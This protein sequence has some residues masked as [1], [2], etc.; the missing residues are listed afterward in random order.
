MSGDAHVRKR[1]ADKR[2]KKVDDSTE[3]TVPLLIPAPSPTNEE[4]IHVHKDAHLGGNFCSKIVFFGLF[5]T[6]AILVGL[7][8]IEFH[9]SGD[10]E[11]AADSPWSVMLEGWVDEAHDNHEHEEEHSV[12]EKDKPY[13]TEAEEHIRNVMSGLRKKKLEEESIEAFDEEPTREVQGDQEEN[14]ETEE[15]GKEEESAQEVIDDDDNEETVGDPSAKVED[16]GEAVDKSNVNDT[17]DTVE[18]IDRRESLVDLDTELPTPSGSEDE[19]MEDRTPEESEDEQVS[20]NYAAKTAYEASATPADSEAES[21]AELTDDEVDDTP[22]RWKNEEADAQTGTEEEEEEEEEEDEEEEETEEEESPPPSPPKPKIQPEQNPRRRGGPRSADDIDFEQE[23]YEYTDITNDYD[24]AIRNEL[25]FAEDEFLN[26]SIERAKSLFS[27]LLVEHPKSVRAYYGFARCIDQIAE[28]LKSNTHLL[29]A[30]NLYARTL[31]LPDISDALYLRVANRTI[32]RMRF[33]GLYQKLIPIHRSLI[34]RFHNDPIHRNN[35][36]VTFLLMNRLNDAK[37]VLEN[38][39]NRWPSDGMAAAHYG[40]ILKMEDNLEAGVKYLKNG[41]ESNHS[42]A[43]DSRFYFH[44]GDALYR[45]GRN[46]EALKVYEIG[47]KRGMFRSLYQRSLYNIDRLVSR[48]WWTLEQTTYASFFRKL[49]ENWQII[50]NEAQA[51]LTKN[52]EFVDEAE[53]LRSVGDWKQFEL[54][55]R[56]RKI[57]DNCRKAPVTCGI[58]SSFEA[59]STCSRGQVKFS[60]M[61]PG[62]H[63]R[64]HCGPTNCRLRAHLGLIVPADTF[65]RVAEEIRSWKE[66]KVLVFDDSFEHEVWH[67]G[68]SARLVLIVDTWH[69]DL[70]QTERRTLAPI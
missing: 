49:E 29:E 25:D 9:G 45:L 47:V 67:N 14:E 43:Q 11:S 2:R 22:D 63:V 68:T 48:P 18:I 65:L 40:F 51:L 31:E 7:L 70:T 55:A 20:E 42:G 36:A 16:K 19:A 61:S 24:W 41:I 60:I 54:F 38:V 57:H 59:A 6:L 5:G 4:N 35:L 69:P 39:L 27:N 26:G 8:I 58:V 37:T 56:G 46:D 28:N 3:D 44:L 62:T 17:S 66:G 52:G 13:E 30:I 64:A 21:N 12:S 15:N 1:G 10:V 53:K 23:Y 33:K 32:E 50:R 34:Q